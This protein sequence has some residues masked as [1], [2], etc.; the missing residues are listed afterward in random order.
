M[1]QRILFATMPFDGHFSPLT[2]IAAHLKDQGH[3]VRWYA[4][5]SYAQKLADLAGVKLGKIISVRDGGKQGSGNP[6]GNNDVYNPP[7][8]AAGPNELT[9]NT[10]DDIP[11]TIAVVVQFEIVK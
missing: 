3:D 8:P 6:S 10:Y 4:G 7:P 2:G 11:M 5:P 1:A 9:S